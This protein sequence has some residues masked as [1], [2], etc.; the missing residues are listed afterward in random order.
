MWQRLSSRHWGHDA[1]GAGILL[2]RREPMHLKL[3]LL[4][5]RMKSLA[6]KLFPACPPGQG[7]HHLTSLKFDLLPETG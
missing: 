2:E 7:T 3:L 5:M 4:A 6:P 1:F